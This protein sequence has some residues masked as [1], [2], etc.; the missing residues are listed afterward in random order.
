MLDLGQFTAAATPFGDY[1]LYGSLD[2]LFGQSE[3]SD[4]FVLRRAP[5]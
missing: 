1:V 2:V 4:N 3:L 5:R